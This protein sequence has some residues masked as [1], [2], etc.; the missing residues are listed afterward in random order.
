LSS[1]TIYN[2]N[3]I[4]DIPKK[5]KIFASGE[6]RNRAAIV[7]ANNQVDTILIKQ[8]SDVDTVLEII[9]KLKLF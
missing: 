9:D 6:G 1:R 2:Y 3:K 5:Y 4:V 7:V 8:L